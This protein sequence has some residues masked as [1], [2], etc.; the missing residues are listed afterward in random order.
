MTHD[1]LK[2]SAATHE[3]LAGSGTLVS[4]HALATEIDEEMSLGLTRGSGQDMVVSPISWTISGN[5]LEIAAKQ[6]DDYMSRAIE[7]RGAKGRYALLIKE[8]TMSAASDPDGQEQPMVLVGL[9]ST[10]SATSAE[11]LREL[12]DLLAGDV[13]R[14]L[15]DSPFDF[16]FP[17]IF[18]EK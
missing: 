10:P 6:I 8:G 1:A 9:V 14:A 4:R 2:R 11:E 17:T 3:F 16:R 7:E 18:P 15:E 12:P 5:G 13:N